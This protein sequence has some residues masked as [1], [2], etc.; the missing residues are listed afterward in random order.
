MKTSEYI[1]FK[2][3]R[4]PKGYIFTYADFIT[5]VGKK[6]AIIKALNRL[7]QTGKI[8]KLTKGKY[9]K[10]E[11]TPFGNLQPSQYQIVK[12]LL[13]ENSKVT[14]YLT[15]YSIYNQLALTTQVVNVIQIGKNTIR[16]DFK[17]DNYT[18]S[19][20]LQ[21][22][23]ITKD[24]IPL[25]QILDSIRYVRKIPDTTIEASVKRLS[26]I[27]SSL[28]DT[29]AVKMIRLSQKY[30]PAT[31][32]LLGAILD[33]TKNIGTEQLYKT[34]NPITKYKLGIP[35]SVLATSPKWNII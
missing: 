19:F 12:D 16:N 5:D 8:A 25:L 24:N 22:N 31:R 32:A 2:I 4:M 15:G 30:P 23:N 13:E 27:V 14:G 7:V 1:S 28:S 26:A 34:L 29:N 21:K 17:R 10:P 11:I 18:I 9:Y 20:I 35:E 3:E 33:N 6:E